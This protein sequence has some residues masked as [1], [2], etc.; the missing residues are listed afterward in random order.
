MS[1]HTIRSICKETAG[2]LPIIP[3]HSQHRGLLSPSFLD[4]P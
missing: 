3:V 2:G 4:E 1:A